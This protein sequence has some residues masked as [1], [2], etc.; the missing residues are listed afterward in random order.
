MRSRVT[1]IK[2]IH[3]KLITVTVELKCC[4]TIEDIKEQNL[5]RTEGGGGAR[6]R[7]FFSLTMLVS[8]LVIL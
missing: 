5:Q 3:L 6:I 7:E 4:Y 1:S 8:S 2:S